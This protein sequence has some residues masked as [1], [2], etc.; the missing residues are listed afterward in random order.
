[1]ENGFVHSKEK[2]WTRFDEQKLRL[3]AEA[4]KRIELKL[5]NGWG[6][7]LTDDEILE[8]QCGDAG[9]AVATALDIWERA[10][11]RPQSQ[12]MGASA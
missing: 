6:S 2:D 1:V 7:D 5:A 11:R 10:K 12:S 3:L 8:H 9:V 4:R